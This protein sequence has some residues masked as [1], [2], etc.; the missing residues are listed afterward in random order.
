M[1]KNILICE[2]FSVEAQ[3][4]LKKNKKFNVENYSDEKL[5][6]AHALIIRSKTKIHK[7]L[8]DQAP[9]LQLIVT[10]TSGFDHI[11]LTETEKRNI[12][13]MFT[14][15]A[16]TIS[17]A[18]LTWSLLLNSTRQVF[19]AN[20]DLKAGHWRRDS[21]TGTELAN[22]TLGLVGLGR[23]GQRVAKIANA[24]DMKVLAFD[25]YVEAE[26]F[27]K[28]QAQRVSYEE[29]LKQSDIISF[30]V[31]ATNETRNMFSRSQLEYVHPDLILINTSRGSVINEDD[32]VQ[33]LSQNKIRFAALDV[34]S[35]EPLTRESKLLKLSNVILTPHIGAFTE[36][37]FLKASLQGARRV[38]EYFENQLT[39]NTLPLKNDWGTLSFSERN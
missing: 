19:A 28:T 21:L 4:E 16:N 1:I 30:H 3:I 27:Q 38:H 24:F 23:I 32:L 36:E 13:V 17:A 12:C 20:K 11:D 26:A 37:A 15:E 18:E 25:P 33:A 6:T 5:K 10:C 35:K 7:D 9:N 34:F 39:Q 22:K 8:L 2:R 29:L 31:P 14:P